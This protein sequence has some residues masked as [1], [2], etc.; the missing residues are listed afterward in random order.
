MKLNKNIEINNC[1]ETAVELCMEKYFKSG[2][3]QNAEKVFYTLIKNY[4]KHYEIYEHYYPFSL[5]WEIISDCN[6]RCKHCY[7]SNYS[8]KYD[9]RNDLST[10]KIMSIIDELAEMNVVNV[11][12]TGGE[13]FL[14]A[15]FLDILKK[16]KSKNISINITTNGTL[17]TENIAKELSFILNPLIDTIQVS[18]DGSCKETHDK[19]RGEGSFKKAIIGINNLVKYQIYPFINCTATIYNVFELA[20]LYKLAQSLKVK[21][22]SVAK[23]LPWSK[24]QIELVP[25]IDTLL[26]QISKVIEIE[27]KQKGLFF[28][29]RTFKFYDFVSHKIAQKKLSKF[30]SSEDDEKIAF[31]PNCICHKH[32]KLNINRDGKVYLCFHA[33]DMDLYSLGDLKNEYLIDIW[34]KRHNNNLFQLRNLNK[35]VCKKCNYANFCRG[36][37]PLSAELS[38]G[39]IESP[40]GNCVY[41]NV[42]MQS[43]N[44]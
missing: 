3:Y 15:D 2:T 17:I 24:E 42:L 11:N 26:I 37:C 5:T 4:V 10:E 30:I 16:L 21:K 9:S 44:S 8:E 20:N 23:M 32:D 36:G 1:L 28:E 41:G 14:R 25:D 18:L 43:E 40:D 34:Y 38:H 13:P 22:M 35:M 12:L 33:A 31:D 29:L 27:K 6:L 19:T 7:F 39:K